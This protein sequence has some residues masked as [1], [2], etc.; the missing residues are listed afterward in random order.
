ME[1]VSGAARFAQAAPVDG[2]DSGDGFGYG[3]GDGCGSG[4]GSGDGHGWGAGS[5]RMTGAVETAVDA[6]IEC[7]ILESAALVQESLLVTEPDGRRADEA[8]KP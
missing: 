5:G 6:I 7:S 2:S 3:F 1:T 8:L 4:D